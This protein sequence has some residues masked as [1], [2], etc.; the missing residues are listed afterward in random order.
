MEKGVGEKPRMGLPLSGQMN[1]RKPP[2]KRTACSASPV[3]PSPASALGSHPCV[4]LSSGQAFEPYQETQY[5]KSEVIRETKIESHKMK[6]EQGK[7]TN[8][9]HPFHLNKWIIPTDYRWIRSGRLL[10]HDGRSLAVDSFHSL[11]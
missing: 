3:H 7:K 1:F 2:A 5:N 10:T 6:N 9:E 4:A 8:F 11:L